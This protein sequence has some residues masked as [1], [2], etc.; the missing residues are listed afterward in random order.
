M[1]RELMGTQVCIC[2]SGMN[3]CTHWETFGSMQEA[4]QLVR[5]RSDNPRD[6]FENKPRSQFDEPES[7]APAPG[8]APTR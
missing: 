6:V 3:E 4:K 2:K 8:A 7:V 5:Q 1:P